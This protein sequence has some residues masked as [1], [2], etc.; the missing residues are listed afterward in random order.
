M[1][2]LVIGIAAA[3]GVTLS[4]KSHKSAGTAHGSNNDG[5]AAAPDA[6]SVAPSVVLVTTAVAPTATANATPT[7]ASATAATSAPVC[8][9]YV[10]PGIGDLPQSFP[11]QVTSA[12]PN[13]VHINVQFTQKMAWDR[14]SANSTQLSSIQSLV[15]QAFAFALAIDVNQ[16]QMGALIP[17]D[18]A[19]ELCYVQTV[20]QVYA[21]NQYTDTLESYAF[22]WSSPLFH[23][24]NKDVYTLMSDMYNMTFPAD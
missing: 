3:I 24:P 12:P 19:A 21:P 8:P 17:N 1:V 10:G 11:G 20:A 22:N 5:T 16:I 7:S 13:T 23:S 9:N 6:T 15:P 18:T 4:Q 14:V 2:A